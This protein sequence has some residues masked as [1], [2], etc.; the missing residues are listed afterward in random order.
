MIFGCAAVVLILGAQWRG[1]AHEDVAGA[2]EVTAIEILR[3]EVSGVQSALKRNE[4]DVIRDAMKSVSAGVAAS[5]LALSPRPDAAPPFRDIGLHGGEVAEVIRPNPIGVSGVL[6]DGD[7]HIL[8]T[9]SVV[10]FSTPVQVRIGPSGDPLLA[11]RISVDQN[12]HLALLKLREVPAGVS[13]INLS[14]ASELAAGEWL[15]RQGRT[16]TGEDARSLHLLESIQRVAPGE[17]TGILQDQAGPQMEG[18][19]LV[20]SIGRIVGVY[21]H[22]PGSGGFVVPIHLAIDIAIGL[23][24]KPMTEAGGW[25]GL[26]LQELS[27]DLKEYFAAERGALVASVDPDSPAS[28]AGLQPGDLIET[29]DKAPANGAEAVMRHIAQSP[30]GARVAFGVRRNSRVQNIDVTVAQSPDA[31]AWQQSVE[32]LL[33]R[34]ERRPAGDEGVTILSMQPRSVANRIGVKD[35]DVIVAVD[36]RAVRSP[37]QFWSMQRNQTE[38]KRSLWTVRRGDKQFFVAVKERVVLP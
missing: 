24:A 25:V 19:A 14:T 23:K 9:A 15:V 10:S 32:G 1:G 11:D 2:S 28:V 30:P 33:L 8:T 20:D 16:P 7:G 17:A 35:G 22:P 18:A 4:L 26:Q 21:V 27:D 3:K 31:E 5:V 37:A 34:L 6:V 13:P 38:D 12:H 36:G 29:I